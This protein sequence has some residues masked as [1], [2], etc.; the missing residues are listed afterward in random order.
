MGLTADT[1][2]LAGSLVRI[3]GRFEAEATG[4]GD[5]PRVAGQ[6]REAV[7]VL[8]DQARYVLRTGDLVHGEAW[9]SAAALVLTHLEFARL[10]RDGRAWVKL[11]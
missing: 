1:V 5:Y 9:L 11:S 7:D 6:C 3:A 10:F 2:N 8:T 4:W